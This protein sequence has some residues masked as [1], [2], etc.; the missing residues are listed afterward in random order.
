MKI[1]S[2][3]GL[4]FINDVSIA[5]DSYPLSAYATTPL[6]ILNDLEISIIDCAISGET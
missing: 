2:H 3:V 6:A 4:Y 1:I 5:G